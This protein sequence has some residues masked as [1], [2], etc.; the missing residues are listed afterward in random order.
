MC[1]WNQE[2]RINKTSNFDSILDEE[3]KKRWE[4]LFFFK[5]SGYSIWT[6]NIQLL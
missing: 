5:S 2:I 3:H 4:I 1:D 6:E